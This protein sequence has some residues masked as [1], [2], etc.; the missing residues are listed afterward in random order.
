MNRRETLKALLLASTSSGLIATTGC[1]TSHNSND[2]GKQ[3]TR[4]VK[5][6]VKRVAHMSNLILFVMAGVITVRPRNLS[7]DRLLRSYKIACSN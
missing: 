7:E 4:P 1:T 2:A 5:M 3:I 6:M